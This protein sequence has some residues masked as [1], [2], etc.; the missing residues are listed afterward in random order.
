MKIAGIGGII[1]KIISQYK[2]LRIKSYLRRFRFLNDHHILSNKFYQILNPTSL[3]FYDRKHNS[4][5]HHRRK[6]L[7][8]IQ[9]PINLAI[10]GLNFNKTYL[11][12]TH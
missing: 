12:E 5:Q 4:N 10:Y 11:N 7:I 8:R 3:N 6:I 9:S 2:C 1:K